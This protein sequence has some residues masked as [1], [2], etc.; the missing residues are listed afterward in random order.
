M[1]IRDRVVE[2][3]DGNTFRTV[4]HTVLLENLNAP[5]PESP[6]GLKAKSW[7]E[8]LLQTG[9]TVTIDETGRDSEGRIVAQVWI[10]SVN[11]NEVMNLFIK[12]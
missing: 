8:W 2:V 3:I 7:L 9:K 12:I 10:D 11:V 4:R 5:T 6:G 1:R